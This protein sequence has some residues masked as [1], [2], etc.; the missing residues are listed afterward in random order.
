MSL[1]GRKSHAN[2]HNGA[3]LTGYVKRQEKLTPF[4]H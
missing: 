3:V 4:R 1:K 2:I